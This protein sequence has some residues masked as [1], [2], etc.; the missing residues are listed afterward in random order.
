VRIGVNMRDWQLA[1]RMPA[2][3]LQARAPLIGH[4]LKIAGHNCVNALH[5][6]FPVVLQ[7]LNDDCC[8]MTGEICPRSSASNFLPALHPAKSGK[9]CNW[10]GLATGDGES[11][12]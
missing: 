1:M 4:F 6:R 11:G 10:L 7:G 9:L 2:Q 12:A 8:S 3:L 5:L